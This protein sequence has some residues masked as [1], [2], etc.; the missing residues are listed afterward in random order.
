M[1]LKSIS[2]SNYRSLEDVALTFCDNYCTISGRNNAGKS[3]VIRLLSEAFRPGRRY[4]HRRDE[5]FAYGDDRTQWLKDS[6]H[7]EVCYKITLNKKEDPALI[8][9][10]EKIAEQTIESESATLALKYLTEESGSMSISVDVDGVN[11][12]VKAAK[13]IDKRIKDSEILFLYNSTTPPE[14]YYYG[15]GRRRMF[16]DFVMSDEEKNA[17]DD[18]GKHTQRALKKFAKRH[19][20]ELSGVLGRLAERYDVN[21]STLEGPSD[22]RMPLGVSLND[23]SVD[24]PL[25]DWGSGTQNRTHILMAILQANR[26]KTTDTADER[27]TPF[28]VVEEPESFLHPSAQAEFGRV[29]RDLSTEF[30][31][32]IIVTT[33]SPYMLNLEEPGANILLAR[34][35]KRKKAV[36]TYAVDTSGDGWMAPFADQLGIGVAEFAEL[37]PLFSASKTHVLLVEGPI[38]QSYFEYLRDHSLDCAKLDPSIEVVPYGGKDTLKN[39][40][41]VQFVLRTFDRVYVTYDLDA[42]TDVKS[43]LDRVGLMVGKDHMPLGVAKPGRD[44]IEGVLPASILSAVNGKETDLV[45]QLGSSSGT[46]RRNAK[47]ALKKLYLEAF[48]NGTKYEAEELHEIDR[49][50]QQINKALL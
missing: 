28:V 27:I 26:I 20:Q 15:P 36:S 35:V 9:F 13:E 25:D 24:V 39:T 50:V 12:D 48:K 29:L 41:L 8:S 44:C 7:I 14:Q 33:H 6:P 40:L 3:S 46:E 21:V 31:I 38:D 5:G 47:N 16:Y 22:R 49:A 45:M 11:V 34:Q 17:L 2:T 42:K 10:V 37:R 19:T 43:A 18:A 23:R 32:Q 30:D 1:K 4:Y